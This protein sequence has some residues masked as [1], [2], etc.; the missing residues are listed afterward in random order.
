[1]NT[2]AYPDYLLVASSLLGM[3]SVLTSV[4]CCRLRYPAAEVPMNEH[5]PAVRGQSVWFANAMAGIKERRIRLLARKRINGKK[6]GRKTM[7][8][9]QSVEAYVKSLPDR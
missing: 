1:M 3:I 5:K 4:L 7:I 2:V 8:D 6:D 9:L